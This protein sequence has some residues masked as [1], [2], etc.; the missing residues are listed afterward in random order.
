M[1]PRSAQIIFTTNIQKLARTARQFL[2]V[3]LTAVL[4]A[5]GSNNSGAYDI[6]QLE[7][8]KTRISLGLTY[9]KNGNYNQAKANLDKAINFAPGLMDSHFAMAYYYQ[10]VEEVVLAEKYYQK[11]LSIDDRNADLLNSYGAFLCLQG[12]Y[13]IAEQYLMRAVNSQQYSHT[14]SSYENLALCS[15]AQA[16]IY[17]AIQ[18]LKTAL[19]HEPGRI[20]SAYL[21][22]ELSVSD[23]RWEEAKAALEK[24]E[25]IAPISA[26]T[27]EYAV[28]I[29]QGLGNV[30]NANGY[31]EML[32][33]LYPD[34]QPA[35]LKSTEPPGTDKAR[36]NTEL[37][38]KPMSDRI[39]VVQLGE[40]L[41]RISLKYNVRMQRLIEW[42]NLK[43]DSQVRVGTNLYVS[44]PNA[45]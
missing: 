33:R 26:R 24:Y 12:H 35:R 3:F 40:N 13:G 37:A 45:N 41:Y 34:Y 7:A 19:S 20:K 30:D 29:E 28:L 44:D 39:H 2:L 36:T 25:K 32:G 5:C 14:A 43:D 42:N 8:A 15:Q 23:Q 21:L 4:V 9:L 11:A 6:N 22:L 1:K 16:N 38:K 10:T 31:R 27:L 17:Q 18:Y